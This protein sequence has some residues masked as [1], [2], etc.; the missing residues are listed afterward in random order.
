MRARL[1]LL[2]LLRNGFFQN[3]LSVNDQL[4]QRV[5]FALS[6]MLVT[7]SLGVNLAYGMATHQQIFRDNAFGNC[8]SILTKVT[9]SSVMGDYLNMVNNDKSANGV[10]PKENYAPEVAASLF[11]MEARQALPIL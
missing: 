6:Q 8:E 11:P 3:A 1:L 7:S 5:A 10:N 2:F 4:R 9:L